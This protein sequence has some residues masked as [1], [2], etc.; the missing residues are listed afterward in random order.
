M[1]VRIFKSRLCSSRWSSVTVGSRFPCVCVRSCSAR[2]LSLS[3]LDSKLQ[4]NW[5]SSCSK[6]VHACVSVLALAVDESAKLT[7]GT[8]EGALPFETRLIRFLFSLIGC[9][10]SFICV[11]VYMRR[12]VSTAPARRASVETCC[13]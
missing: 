12:F 9:L 3:L 2:S 5:F 10:I 4:V 8:N 6:R 13:F 1:F 7:L 11:C